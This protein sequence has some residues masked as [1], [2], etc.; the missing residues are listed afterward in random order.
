MFYRERCT[1]P[2]TVGSTG[3]LGYTSAAGTYV[4]DPYTSLVRFAPI[5]SPNALMK[6]QKILLNYLTV[7]VAMLFLL[8]GEN[9][10]GQNGKGFFETTK[11]MGTNI[12][13][14]TNQAQF[15]SV[16]QSYGFI[17]NSSSGSTFFLNSSTINWTTLGGSNVAAVP[18]NTFDPYLA[19][20]NATNAL[21]SAAWEPTS[22]FQVASAYLTQ[23][24]TKNGAGQTN[25]GLLYSWSF[26]DTNGASAVSITE[27]G[28]TGNSN[29][30]FM[31]ETNAA[32]GGGTVTSVGATT[33]L[34]STGGTTP[35]IYVSDNVGFGPIVEAT[36]T[37]LTS[38][39]L[40]NVTFLGPAI[41]VFTN[42]ADVFTLNLDG[43]GSSSNIVSGYYEA[44]D[45]NN[46]LSGNF[47][48]NTTGN[49]TATEFFG[50]GAGLTAVPA[51]SISSPPWA[52]N[53]PA[54]IYNAG[55]NT[56]NASQLS[57]GTVPAAQMPALTGDITTTSGTVATALKNTGTAGTYTKTTFD[58]QGRE[59]SGTTLAFSD[60]PSTYN[61]LTNIITNGIAATPGMVVTL[62]SDGTL[63]LSN[64]VSGPSVTLV[65][66]NDVK[67]TLYTS[68]SLAISTNSSDLWVGYF[69]SSHD[70]N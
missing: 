16:L 47:S 52:T 51:S 66:T 58:A 57:S 7:F 48:I 63:T 68:T 24:A 69:N 34:G 67:N 49:V 26:V 5:F 40:T 6:I 60:M 56:N 13:P 32:S 36:N 70:S 38:P 62:K 1:N 8:I 15:V 45:T 43:S 18:A 4:L 14:I 42:T 33:P 41:Y 30:L 35:S 19:A 46:N 21:N 29:V 11:W 25:Q 64:G 23:L 53:T 20:Y 55:G 22:F 50:S 2:T 3:G 37:Y 31:I 28:T 17:T 12:F 44:R 65:P 10:S 59:T 9:S 54:G 39:T 61:A 27:Q